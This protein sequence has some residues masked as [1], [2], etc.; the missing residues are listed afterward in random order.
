MA[1]VVNESWRLEVQIILDGIL[2]RLKVMMTEIDEKIVKI[3][4]KK[5]TD[6]DRKLHLVM[7]EKVMAEVEIEVESN[8]EDP[9]D[10]KLEA[11]VMKIQ[12]KHEH[13]TEIAAKGKGLVG[14]DGDKSNSLV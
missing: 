2:A 7:D 11:N 6:G 5:T 1:I 13:P 12:V 14:M 4:S 3:K 8:V 10:A 9:I